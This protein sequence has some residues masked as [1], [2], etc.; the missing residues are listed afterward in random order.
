[1][2]LRL[3]REPVSHSTVQCLRQLLEAAERGEIVGL[4]FGA[5]LKGKRYMVNTAGEAYRNPTFTRGMICA[6]D[7][8]LRDQIH[9]AADADTTL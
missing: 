4:A 5:V 3:V 9:A 1:M 6:L 2:A 8:D 7:D